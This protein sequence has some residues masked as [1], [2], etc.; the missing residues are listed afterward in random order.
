MRR[1]T[2]AR[3]SARII[4]ELTGHTDVSIRRDIARAQREGN[5]ELFAACMLYALSHERSEYVLG[6]IWDEQYRSEAED[7]VSYF[8]L[9]DLERVALLNRYQGHI[10]S[11]YED[12]LSRFRESYQSP[13]KLNEV[14]ESYAN[15]LRELTLHYGVS[16][17]SL[18]RVIGKDTSNVTAFIQ[19][20]ELGRLSESDARCALAWIKDELINSQDET[21][22]EDTV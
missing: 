9:R 10:P 16:M 12:I 5:D 15:E 3:Y 17:A 20:K 6:R 1:P 21:N 11:S 18:A 19:R 7:V 13:E 14:K 8:G 2:F 22:E 4:K